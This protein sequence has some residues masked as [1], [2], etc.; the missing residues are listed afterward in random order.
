MLFTLSKLNL[1][2]TSKDK[3]IYKD[4]K[5]KEVINFRNTN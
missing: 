4:S 3:N 2:I 5:F 1:T